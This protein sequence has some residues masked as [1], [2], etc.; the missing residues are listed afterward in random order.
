MKYLAP[1]ALIAALAGTSSAVA[2]VVVDLS[3]VD[4]NSPEYTRF[5]VSSIT[6]CSTRPTPVIFSRPPMPPTCSS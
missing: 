5:K 1:F 3:Y 2:E 4:M 6:R